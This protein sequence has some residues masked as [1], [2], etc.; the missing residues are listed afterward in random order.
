MVFFLIFAIACTLVTGFLTNFLGKYIYGGVVPVDRN[1]KVIRLKKYSYEGGIPEELYYDLNGDLHILE[2]SIEGIRLRGGLTLEDDAKKTW[3]MQLVD[4]ESSIRVAD[5][6]N[7]LA[8]FYFVI[9]TSKRFDYVD[10]AIVE[11]NGSIVD[12]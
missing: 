3:M 10:S 5:A 6:L 7:L 11:S 2:A 12:Q 8:S 4:D 1:D 9:E